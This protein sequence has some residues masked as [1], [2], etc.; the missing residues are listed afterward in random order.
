MISWRLC[1]R[2]GGWGSVWRCE[3]ERGGRREEWYEGGS[4][5][6]VNAQVARFLMK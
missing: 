3:G 2:G 1:G 4:E 5:G 6:V